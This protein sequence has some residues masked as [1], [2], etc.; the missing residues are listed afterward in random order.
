[1][2]VS[3]VNA[4]M[5]GGVRSVQVVLLSPESYPSVT[6]TGKI[7]QR[8]TD[9]YKWLSV[10]IKFAEANGTSSRQRTQS[11][12]SPSTGGVKVSLS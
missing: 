1:M 3:A 5:G 11:G 7:G 12:P 10:A 9:R 6:C 8:L 4:S 2:Y